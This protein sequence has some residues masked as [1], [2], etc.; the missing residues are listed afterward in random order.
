[1]RPRFPH[2]AWLFAVLLLAAPAGFAQRGRQQRPKNRSARQNQPK[3]QE[4]EARAFAGLPP[5]WAEKLQEM[6]PEEQDRFLKNNAR[7]KNLPP[8]RQA[9]IRDRLQR[10]NSLAPD[11]REALRDRQ[12]VWQQM[13]PQQHDY[14]RKSLLPEWQQLPDERKQMIRDRLHVLHDLNPAERTQ[15]LQ[16]PQFLQ[17]LAPNEQDLLRNMNSL[18]NPAPAG[19][20]PGAKP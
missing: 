4:D 9:Q 3:S 10:W 2:L 17:G 6:P 12:R 13:S 18:E 20:V 8:Q 16:D 15:K 14:I 19:A 1:M 11:Q 7:F 5:K